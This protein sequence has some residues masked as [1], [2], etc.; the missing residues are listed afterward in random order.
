MEGRERGEGRRGGGGEG[1]G[2]RERRGEE[3][4]AVEWTYGKKNWG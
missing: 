1:R 3:R 2:E 4:L